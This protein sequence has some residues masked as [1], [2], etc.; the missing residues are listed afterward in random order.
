MVNEY[1]RAMKIHHIKASQSIID[2]FV[3][4]PLEII[5]NLVKLN[6]SKIARDALSMKKRRVE[7]MEAEMKAPGR[8]CA[9][10]FDARKRFGPRT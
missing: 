1:A 2:A 7:P 10:A 6:W 9:Y 4:S 8:E 5:E 3:I